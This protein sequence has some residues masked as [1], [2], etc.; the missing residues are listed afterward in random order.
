LYAPLV[1]SGSY[2]ICEDGI[3]EILFGRKGVLSATCD[4]LAAHPEFIADRTCER[5]GLTNCPEG[6]LLR[7]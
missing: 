5:Y 4:F 2:L 3:D 7:S 6:F 1:S